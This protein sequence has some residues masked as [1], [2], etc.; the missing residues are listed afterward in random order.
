ML[1]LTRWLAIS[2]GWVF[3]GTYISD[4]DRLPLLQSLAASRKRREVL[5]SPP[6]ETPS[7]DQSFLERRNFAKMGKIL[8]DRRQRSRATRTIAG[9]AL[10]LS[11]ILE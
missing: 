4:L 9:E 5:W 11:W 10:N 8:E 6:T 3:H 1:S 2:L 7:S